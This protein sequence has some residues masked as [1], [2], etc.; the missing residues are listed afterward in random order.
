MRSRTIAILALLLVVAACN[1]EK[2]ERAPPPPPPVTVAKPVVKDVVEI[3]EYTGRFDA[4]ASVDVRARVN[5]Y[6][7]SVN[8]RDGAIVRP[9]DLLFVIDPRPY[10]AVYNQ[11]QALLQSS[12][13]RL[14]FTRVEFER[15]DRLSRTGA[16]SVATLDQRRQDYQTEQAT[17]AANR[18]ALE[19]ARLN[20]EFTEI[21][22]P[23]AGRISRPLVT[24]GNLVEA[25]TTIL[26]TLVSIDPIYFYFDIDEGT[27]LGYARSAR[28]GDR[29]SGREVTFP[30]AVALADEKTADHP[31]HFD[32][33]DNRI[34]Q[35]TGTLRGRAVIGNPDRLLLPGL[36][37]RIEIPG[38]GHYH[39]VLIPDEAI[40]SDQDRRFVWVVGDDGAVAARVV[41]PGPRIDGYRVIR[42]G[43]TGDETIV[44][45]GVQ[46]ARPGA[47]V[48]PQLV[49]L[50]P[51]AT[52][53]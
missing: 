19:L 1:E 47:K 34:D 17:L 48:T 26:T 33:V 25:N 38:S 5:G 8:F 12:E 31:G 9:G 44:I 46:R 13:T 6:L 39:G 53:P 14:D 21:R 3:D 43:L 40:A 23:I 45:K 50:P 24:S 27:Y 29:Q 49:T 52:A 10:Q 4:M 22:A 11:A 7:Q 51:V 36:F 2:S 16:G 30:V 20:L 28:A 15:A 42:T 41:R 35:G 37:G 32:F 18:A